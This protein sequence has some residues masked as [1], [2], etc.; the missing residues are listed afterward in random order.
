MDTNK[1]VAPSMTRFL[2][3]DPIVFII[4]LLLFRPCL[5]NLMVKFVSSHLEKFKLQML[6][7]TKI[8]HYHSPLDAPSHG[9]L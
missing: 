9:Q 4:L 6:M 2:L 7:K 5:L 1:I 8:T 3:L